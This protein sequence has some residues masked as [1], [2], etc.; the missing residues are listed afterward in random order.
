MGS[1]QHDVSTCWNSTYDMLEFALDYHTALNT[2]TADWDIKLW[3]FKLSKKEQAMASE[4]CKALQVHPSIYVCQLSKLPYYQIF[5]HGT[6]FFSCDTP[7][8][9]T[10]IPAMDHIDKYL[11]TASQD[12]TYSE[13]ICAALALGKQTLN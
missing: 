1:H 3:Q 2:M 5:K 8:I 9:S 12:P 7:S 13:A 6:L 10:I 11:A 4:L